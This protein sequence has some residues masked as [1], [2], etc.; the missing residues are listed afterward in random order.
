MGP[1][2]ESVTKVH[3]ADAMLSLEPQGRKVSKLVNSNGLD[4]NYIEYVGGE[5]VSLTE[6]QWRVE[7]TSLLGKEQ[8]HAAMD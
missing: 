6:A 4:G 8:T 5:R 3:E 1:I 7:L 2:Q